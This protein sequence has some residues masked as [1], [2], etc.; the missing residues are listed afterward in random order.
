MACGSR[1]RFV[2]HL[3]IDHAHQVRIVRA[4]AAGLMRRQQYLGA[5]QCGDPD[6]FNQVNVV[7]MRTPA[8]KPWGVSRS[9]FGAGRDVI[10][11]ECVKFAVTPQPAIRHCHHVGVIE[12]VPVCSMRPA[13]M[14]IP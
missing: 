11:L 5:Q 6:V 9:E 8:R 2:P 12:A 10:I 13:P 14:V 1:A 3:T 7:A 4:A